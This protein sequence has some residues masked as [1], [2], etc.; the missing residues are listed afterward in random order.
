MSRPARRRFRPLALLVGCVLLLTGGSSAQDPLLL[1]D[2]VRDPA[3]APDGRVAVSV[4]GDLW[5][6]SGADSATTPRRLTTG[7]SW[8]REPAWTPD[9]RALVFSSDRSGAFDLWRIQVD[10]AIPEGQPVRL[11][12][13]E[14]AEGRP[15]VDPAGRVAFVR[16]R[17]PGADLW[18]LE[19]DGQARLLV[20]GAGEQTDPAFSPAGSRLAYVDQS[21]EKARLR[22][23]RLSDGSERTLISRDRLEAPAWSPDG[24]AVAYGA[25]GSGT[26]VVTVEE[27]EERRVALQ[28]TAPVWIADGRRLLLATLP[29]PPPGYN[30][31]PDRL[32]DRERGDYFPPAGRLELRDP[33]AEAAQ[34]GPALDVAF[35]VVT[36]EYAGEVLEE[37]ARRVE[38]LYLDEPGREEARREWRATVRAHRPAVLSS[39]DE[40]E[41]ESRIHE[42]L[43]ARPPARIPARGRAGV[44]SA[45]PLATRAGLEVLR[46]GGNV[47]DAAVAISFV[48][49]VVEPDASGVGGYGQMVLRLEG[50]SRPTAI[51]F[52]TRVPEAGGL[53]SDAVPDSLPSHGPVLANV[54][55][56]VAGMHLAWERYGSGRIPWR[57]LVEPARR[58]AE[59]GFVLDEAIPTT[60]AREEAGFRTYPSS[61]EL[62]FPGGEP[63]QPGDTLRNPGLAWVLER[64]GRGGADAFYRGEVGRRIVRD[65]Q[66]RGSPVTLEDLD[67]YRAV[68]REPVVA[69]YRGHTVYGSA[70]PTS[71]G[72]LLAGKLHLAGLTDPGGTYV[73]NAGSLHALVE[74][75]KLAPSTRGR[76]ADPDHWPVSVA[77]FE[78]P[79]TARARWACFRPDRA[80]DVPETPEEWAACARGEPHRRRGSRPPDSAPAA[81]GDREVCAG[82]PSRRRDCPGA[83]TTAFTVADAGGDLVAVTQTLGTWGGGF[84]VSPGLGF[85]YNDKL[86]SYRT[87]PDEYNARVPFARNVTS[88]SPTLVFRGTDSGA[89]PL[90]AVGAAGNAWI[91]SAVY[92]AVVGVVDLGLGPQEALELPRFLVAGRSGSRVVRFERGL[93][94]AV[95]RRLRAMGHDLVPVSLTGE[96]RMGYGA[97]VLL[98]DGWVDAGADP[99]RS[100]AAGAIR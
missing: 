29:P 30:G 64:I 16:G 54:P 44:S 22:L 23:R 4:R 25:R 42:L 48:L 83:G 53:G 77:A 94:P 17:G 57:E 76:V 58:I 92:Q 13:S 63:L 37:T 11:T 56:T 79:D 68:E 24:N 69:R 5:I 86:R 100:G 55:G 51:E 31:D 8:D 82:E 40:T 41:L 21:G 97:A 18:L 45:H 36:T 50:M 9:G 3:A 35:P 80:V 49:G 78:S 75:W 28:G 12:R 14:E 62:F 26:W 59:E 93:A 99:R 87:D 98:R 43:G 27:G 74:A 32:G 47:V 65:L 7:S 61:R 90:L 19:G 52:L 85:L 10:D 34:E 33:G 72:A 60:L 38:R 67:R 6:L 89:R 91:T 1:R 39:A 81:E 66:L 71:G 96:L 73:E 95:V 2:G 88:I 84:Y 20:G 70:P 15:S 46:A